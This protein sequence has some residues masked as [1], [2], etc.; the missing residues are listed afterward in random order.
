MAASSG[1]RLVEQEISDEMLTVGEEEVEAGAG[2]AGL[3]V[4]D[5]SASQSEQNEE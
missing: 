5:G 3:S 4:D 1:E 2:E